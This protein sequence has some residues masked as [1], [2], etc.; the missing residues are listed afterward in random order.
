MNA[1]SSGISGDARAHPLSQSRIPR[2]C[3]ANSAGIDGGREIQEVSV[4]ADAKGAVGELKFGNAK[5]RE[6]FQKDASSSID[7]MD[8]LF[9]SH[10]LN[11]GIGSGSDL[12][13]IGLGRLR[14]KCECTYQDCRNKRSEPAKLSG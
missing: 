10:F 14:E 9:Q 7:L 2:R 6:G 8:F 3:Q 1:A 4:I 5:I 13:A 11:D 12:I